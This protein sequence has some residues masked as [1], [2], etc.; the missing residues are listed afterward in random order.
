MKRRRPVVPYKL[1]LVEWEDS[2]R[3]S[4]SWQW[5]D[6]CEPPEAVECVSVGYLIAKTERALAIAA[7]LGD[8]TRDRVQASGIIQIPACAVRRL[9]E[10]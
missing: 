3:P 6:E 9:V 5:V 7:N 8:V 1:V 10:L 2:A 4:P